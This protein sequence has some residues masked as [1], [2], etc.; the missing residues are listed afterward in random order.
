VT[1]ENVRQAYWEENIGGFA[2]FYDRKSEERILA[3][4]GLAW[5]YR[6]F[7]F[8]IEK[9]YMKVRYDLVSSYLTRH[10]KQG[11]VAADIGCGDGIFTKKMLD[12]GAEK[13]YALDFTESALELTRKRLGSTED[14][15]VTFIHSD[16]SKTPIP[17]V[18]VAIAIGVL[19]YVSDVEAFFAN[20]LPHTER[21]LVNFVSADNPL[22]RLRRRLTVLDVRRLTYQR[23]H[24]IES[25]LDRHGFVVT[26]FDPLAT[27]FM[28]QTERRS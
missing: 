21:L 23:M 9:R 1:E 6:R 18:E 12:L 28:L 24:E 13:V 10:V 7:L 2:G 16:I 17:K 5:L 11:T 22:N 8:P 3:P 25:I 20:V 15:R 14:E 19:V 26:H 27:G 4:P